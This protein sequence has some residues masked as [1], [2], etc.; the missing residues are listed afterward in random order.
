MERKIT[1]ISQQKKV[2]RNKPHFFHKDREK[3]INNGKI[4]NLPANMSKDNTIFDKSVKLEKLPTG[5]TIPRPGPTLLKQVA[6]APNVDVKSIFCKDTN[7]SEK[8]KSKKYKTQYTWILA[9]VARDKYLPSKWTEV[10]LWGWIICFISAIAL[11][12]PIIRRET[13]MPPPVEPA[14]APINISRTRMVCE[15]KGHW[16]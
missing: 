8:P 7:R 11:F 2:C 6:T 10:T 16:P 15:N 5:P 3:N 12:T 14:Q 13:F 1:K 9:N 4:S